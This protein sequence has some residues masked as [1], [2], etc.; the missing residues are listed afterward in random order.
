MDTTRIAELID[1]LPDVVADARQRVQGD[2]KWL[3][4][5]DEAYSWILEA[6]EVRHDAHNIYIPSDDGDGKVYRVNGHC[7]C[8]AGT[9]GR[10]CKHRVR[11]R[12]LR[13]AL[14]QKIQ[15]EVNELFA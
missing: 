4:R 2:T 6:E 14:S 11:A 9:S 15:A 13:L 5:I 8:L 10:M 3:D 12:L 7:T 1:Y